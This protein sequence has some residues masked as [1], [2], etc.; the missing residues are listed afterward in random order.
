MVN[1]PSACSARSK[2]SGPWGE[3]DDGEEEKIDARPEGTAEKTPGV[4]PDVGIASRELICQQGMGTC[5]PAS[6]TNT[7]KSCEMLQHSFEAVT[8]VPVTF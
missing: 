7:R 8:E 6:D 3:G 4:R 2:D 5:C 1:H